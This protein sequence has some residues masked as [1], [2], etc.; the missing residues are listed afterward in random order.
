M[1]CDIHGFVRVRSHKAGPW[2]F[3]S[4][5]PSGRNYALF[6]LL[7]GV[8]NYDEATPISEPR[9]L[10]D[11]LQ[12]LIDPDRPHSDDDYDKPDY[13][14][15]DVGD[16]SQSFFSLKEL[17]EWDGWDRG[18][19]RTRLLERAEYERVKKEGGEP[20]SCDAWG[21]AIVKVS[22]ADVENGSAPNNWTHVWYTW[23]PP[24][25]DELKHFLGW[26]EYLNT[27]YGWMERNGGDVQIVIGFDS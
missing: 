2:H 24:M 26:L 12:W 10:P 13:Y 6:A 18:T 14:F 19:P 9:G 23:T 17:R 25:R 1:G 22:Q 15:N 5:V 11:D 7:A 3:V 16:H 27:E 8:R 20:K 21:P 4:T